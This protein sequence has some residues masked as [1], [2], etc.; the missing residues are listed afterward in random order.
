MQSTH[1][2][3]YCVNGPLKDT[4]IPHANLLNP[5]CDNDNVMGRKTLP[6]TGKVCK[7]C[8][9]SLPT[10]LLYLPWAHISG[11]QSKKILSNSKECPFMLLLQTYPS[12]NHLLLWTALSPLPL[13]KHETGFCLITAQTLLLQ[14]CSQNLY[15]FN[16][17][18]GISPLNPKWTFHDVQGVSEF[19]EFLN[20]LFF[21]I[22]AFFLRQVWGKWV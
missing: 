15:V 9:Q 19:R 20:F 10:H 16:M 22:S 5:T 17:L 13:E 18:S 12:R 2:S 6:E 8:L 21:H 4:H 7:K 14:F 11:V 1:L 3:W